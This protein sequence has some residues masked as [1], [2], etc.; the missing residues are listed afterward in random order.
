MIRATVDITKSSVKYFIAACCLSALYLPLLIPN[1]SQSHNSVAHGQSPALTVGT[2]SQF[3]ANSGLFLPSTFYTTGASQT[4]FS[5]LRAVAIGDLN[6]D[7]RD[8]RT[9]LEQMIEW[10]AERL[11]GQKFDDMRI[12]HTRLRDVDGR[13]QYLISATTERVIA[14]YERIF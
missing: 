14:Q 3:L 11:L 1:V 5:R 10:K 4:I 2:K 13:P 9:E 8:D 12:N 6:S 7:G